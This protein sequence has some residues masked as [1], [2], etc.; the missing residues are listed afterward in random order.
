MRRTYGCS[1][2]LR[3]MLASQGQHYVKD[4]RAGDV[5][6]LDD[7]SLASFPSGCGTLRVGSQWLEIIGSGEW[8]RNAFSGG[9][10]QPTLREGGVEWPM[11]LECEPARPC[12]VPRMERGQAMGFIAEYLRSRSPPRRLP[13][14]WGRAW[15]RPDVAYEEVVLHHGLIPHVL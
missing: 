8:R 4:E 15:G 6:D 14:R 10:P 12:G 5:R 13:S 3:V 1:S 11:R 7:R 9:C 2:R